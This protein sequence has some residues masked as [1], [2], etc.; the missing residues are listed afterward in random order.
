M[1]YL[2]LFTLPHE[3][4]KTTS[5]ISFEINLQKEKQV[6]P[7]IWFFSSMM[8]VLLLRE[9]HQFCISCEEISSFLADVVCIHQIKNKNNA[10][11]CSLVYIKT[12][13][14]IPKQSPLDEI[15]EKSSA[16]RRYNTKIVLSK[17]CCIAIIT[18]LTRIQLIMECFCCWYRS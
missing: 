1:V 14:W 17:N 4:L 12:I 13:I 11:T 15:Q 9:N 5:L 18:C 2:Q 7:V 8:Q 6:I 16:S 3:H 10:V